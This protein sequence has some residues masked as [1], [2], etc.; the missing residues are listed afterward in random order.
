MSSREKLFA[1]LLLLASWM[2]RLPSFNVQLQKLGKE[3][4]F[5]SFSGYSLCGY[6]PPHETAWGLSAFNADMTELLAA[7]TLREDILG[8]V[9]LHFNDD[10]TEACRVKKYPGI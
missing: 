9:C 3:F 7:V 1:W 2:G 6:M 4:P 10:M 5:P 8:F